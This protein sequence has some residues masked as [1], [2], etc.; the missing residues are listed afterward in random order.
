MTITRYGLLLLFVL[1][2][3]GSSSTWHVPETQT[4]HANLSRVVD[5][6]TGEI[7][8]SRETGP[9][10]QPQREVRRPLAQSRLSA[11]PQN[12]TRPSKPQFCIPL[13]L[14]N[15]TS[16]DQV[17]TLPRSSITVSWSLLPTRGLGAAPATQDV[18]RAIASS[19]MLQ[20]TIGRG[21]RRPEEDACRRL[22]RSFPSGVH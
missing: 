13:C 6:F 12:F 7:H 2:K 21:Q 1:L 9:P 22:P 18:R 16:T 17:T 19:A 10:E 15:H 8:H 5:C 3:L 11:A 4:R 20:E 14:A